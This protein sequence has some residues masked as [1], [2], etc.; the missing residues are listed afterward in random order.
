M[1]K[2]QYQVAADARECIRLLNFPLS[3]DLCLTGEPDHAACGISDP[4]HTIGYFA[5]IHAITG[6]YLSHVDSDAEFKEMIRDL[7]QEATEVMAGHC[8]SH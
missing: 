5:I 2:T 3:M 4:M 7:E 1:P 6:H 8:H